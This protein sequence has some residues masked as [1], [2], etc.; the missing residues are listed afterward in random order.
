M[1][2][3]FTSCRFG[4]L[5]T[6]EVGARRLTGLHSVI[7]RVHHIQRV[8]FINVNNTNVNNVT[9]ILTGRN[10]RVDNSSL[11]PGP[12]ARRLVG[13]KTAV[14]FG[15]HPRGMHSTDIIIISDTVSTSGPRVITT[16]RTHVPIVHHT[17]VLT[18]LVHFHRN[19]TVTKARNGAAAATVISDV[20]TRTKLSPAFIGNKL[21]GTTKIRTHLKRNQCLVTR[22]SRDSTSFLRLRPVITVI[23]GVR[24]SRVSACR[25]SF[26]GLGRAFVGFLRGLPFC[27]HTIVY[28]SSPIVHRLLPQIK[29]RAAACNFDRSTS[30]HMRSCRRV[31]PRKRF[32][33][34]HRSGRPVHIALG[35]PNHRGTL[36]T[37]T[38]ITITAR[39]KVSSR[40]VLHTLR[41][42]RKAKHHFSF[43]NRFPLRPIGNG[44]N[45]TVL[46]SSCNRRPARIS[47]AVGTTHTN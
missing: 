44:D 21:M 29:H 16:R 11:T 34:L 15:R 47:T 37:T 27:N 14:C 40:T 13:L 36:G 43:L 20:C 3:P 31:N 12:I 26:R 45:A 18:R 4:G 1:T 25:N 10:C 38:T 22:T 24:T 35:T 32:A 9:R 23:A 42:F 19:V 33:L 6:W 17:R 28:I 30:I 7:P 39:R 46:I 41:D 2:V 5:V 8:R